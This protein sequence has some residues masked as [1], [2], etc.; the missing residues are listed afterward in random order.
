MTGVGKSATINSL[1]GDSSAAINAFEPETK[2]VRVVTG[3]V[4]GVKMKFI[5]TPGLVPSASA[6]GK[7]M[8]ILS[9]VKICP[10]A[11]RE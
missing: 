4:Q 7:N 5:D 8:R 2:K 1:L 6:T 3:T 11:A 9:Q 10:K